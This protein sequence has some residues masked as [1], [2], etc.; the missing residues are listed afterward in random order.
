MTDHDP[1]EVL[2][3][4]SSLNV[5]GPPPIDLAEPLGQGD[6]Q[7]VTSQTQL[8][9]RS[10]PWNIEGGGK[11]ISEKES[12]CPEMIFE[13]SLKGWHITGRVKKGQGWWG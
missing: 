6:S 12:R 10:R 2:R 7:E 1:Q 13:R 4:I 8:F 3:E 5:P 9:E 11:R